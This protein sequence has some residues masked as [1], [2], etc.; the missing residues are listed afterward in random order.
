VDSEEKLSPTRRLLIGA[1]TLSMAAGGFAAG[2][3][4]FRPAGNV[5]QP[6][7]FNH[8]KH[9]R[10]AGMECS[11]CHEYYATRQH[12]GLPTLETCLGCHEEASTG[13]P[14]ER[15]LVELAKK[16]PGA[17]FRKLFHLPEHVYYSHRRHVAIAHL[18]CK[19]FHGGIEETTSPPA[20]P[21]VRIT[22]D[23]CISCHSKRGV[24]T[25]CT[26]CHR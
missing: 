11:A 4:L 18:E 24:T 14:E 1:L 7:R 12:S 10:D 22:M 8:Q 21:L 26:H 25:D 13:S 23:T 20:A 3:V 9:V 6:I 2:R 15:K 5:S 16:D 17:S 19:T